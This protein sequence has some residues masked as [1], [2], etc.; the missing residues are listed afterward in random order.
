MRKLLIILTVNRICEKILDIIPVLAKQYKIDIYNVGEMSSKSPWY[1]DCDPREKWSSL[2]F[3]HANKIIDGDPFINQGDCIK[4]LNNKLS[5]NEYSLVIYDD[6]RLM[7]QLD[8][9]SLYNECKKSN[10]PVVGN[11]HGNWDYHPNY[12]IGLNNV[13]DYVMLLGDKEKRYYKKFYDED[14]LLCGGIPGNDKLL[15]L[16]IKKN[17]ILIILNFLGNHAEGKKLF[18]NYF[19]KNFVIKSGI[20]KLSKK[21]NLPIVVKQKTR[22]DDKDYKKN[23]LFIRKCFSDDINLTIIS[24][25]DDID[26][27]ISNSAFVISAIS[28]LAF[29]PIQIG[30][31]TC[32]INGTGQTG[33]FYNYRGLS[34][35]EQ[36]NIVSTLSNQL[37]AAR[38]K[39]FIEDTITGGGNFT[40][41]ESY[42]KSINKLLNK[43]AVI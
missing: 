17:H 23:V 38:N 29:K 33:N 36:D 14:R 3:K 30:I 16:K 34:E 42:I 1:G 26:E 15:N 18:K 2:Y 5:I 28:T 19:N 35:L 39:S 22:L 37:I 27:L 10:I 32:V 41:T 21:L 9:C 8:M 20:E 25:T 7:P 4:I 31:P 43:S 6:N 13:F 12:L 11:S 40:S 24:D